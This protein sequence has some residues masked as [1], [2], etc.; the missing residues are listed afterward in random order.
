MMIEIFLALTCALLALTM[1]SA[2]IYSKR[3]REAKEEYLRAKDVVSD[4]VISFNRQLNRQA[5]AV[6]STNSRAETAY[7][8]SEILER[9]IG[10]LERKIDGL[11]SS[12]ESL[13]KEVKE[14]HEKLKTAVEER[15]EIEEL[16]RKIVE[17]EELNYRTVERE[18]V[19]MEE[20]IS[21]IPIPR[22]RDKVLASLTSTELAVLKILVS[23]GPKTAPQIKDR[24][25]LTR[26]HTA[27]LMKKLY[28]KGFL[29]RDTSK[30]PYS[31]RIK[32]EML[33][34]LKKEKSSE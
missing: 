26:E 15:K 2:F 9:K 1:A 23:E 29:E 13:K 14:F 3:I 25:K 34:L 17:L 8:R 31:Y 20:R 19:E 5:E 32:E 11:E 21:T 18:E 7:L 30:I 4:I 16:K 24:I 33:R 28:E 12:L 22:R 27:R 6:A 10:D